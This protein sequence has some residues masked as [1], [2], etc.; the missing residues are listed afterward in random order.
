MAKDYQDRVLLKVHERT[1]PVQAAGGTNEAEVLKEVGAR[2]QDEIRTGKVFDN[3]P[4]IIGALNAGVMPPKNGSAAP[5]PET[6]TGPGA[7]D[8][9]APVQG[10]RPPTGKDNVKGM[11]ALKAMN[12]KRKAEAAARKA[13]ADQTPPAPPIQAADQGVSQ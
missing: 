12:D 1:A 10:K 4:R 13:G 9:P 5:A 6:S 8:P 2:L 11:A 7:A 3:W